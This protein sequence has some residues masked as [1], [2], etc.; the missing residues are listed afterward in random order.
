MSDKTD[1]FSAS[2]LRFQ[3]AVMFFLLRKFC[4]ERKVHSN[5]TRSVFTCQ[6]EGHLCKTRGAREIEIAAGM[7]SSET[8]LVPSPDKQR[9][10]NDAAKENSGKRETK[11]ARTSEQP[12]Q[13]N[14]ARGS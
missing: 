14:V 3:F 9:S 5:T 11:Q 8:S 12:L 1:I 13:R 4:G 2:E 6:E 7:L 10:N